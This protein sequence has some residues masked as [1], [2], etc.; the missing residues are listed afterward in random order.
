MWVVNN[1]KITSKERGSSSHS[2]SPGWRPPAHLGWH[3]PARRS[4]GGWR[5]WGLLWKRGG[6]KLW[7]DVPG[8]WKRDVC[9]WF[10][11]FLVEFGFS[12]NVIRATRSEACYLP[13]FNKFRKYSS[14]EKVREKKSTTLILA[15]NDAMIMMNNENKVNW[16]KNL[17]LQWVCNVQ[18]KLLMWWWRWWWC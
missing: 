9:R 3:W 2:T 10:V 6:K 5:R 15:I 8:K 18:T 4:P 16:N 14:F 11:C 13:N 7:E 12:P 1:N 17:D